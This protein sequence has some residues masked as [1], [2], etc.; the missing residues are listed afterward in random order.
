MLTFIQR[1]APSLTV[2]LLIFST[3]TFAQNN[4]FKV[5]IIGPFTGPSADF[6][7]PMLNGI[8]LAVEE[9]NA[10]GGYL[11]RPLQLVIKDDKANPD[12]GLKQSQA[13]I[14]EKVNVVVGFC[15]TGVAAK[16]LD[17]F[18]T[19]KIPLIIP[20]STGSPLTA[21]FPAPESYI[22]RTSAKDAIQ[23]PFVVEDILKRGW[24]KIAIFA[25]KTG[26]GEAGLQDVLKAL[27]AK[28]IKPVHVARFDVGVK[29]LSEEMKAAKTAGAE[30]IFSYTV[31]P[32]NAVIAKS[33]QA[34]GWKVPQVGAWPLS[35]PF[36]IDG[37]KEAAEGALMAQTFIAEPSNERRAAF[38]TAYARKY[39]TN[40]ISVPMAAA[41]G[42]DAMYILMYS[43]FNLRDGNTAGSAIKAA[44][45]NMPRIYYGVVAT[46][47][48]PFSSNDKDA[49][50]A[51]MLVMGQV[52]NGLV[53]FAYPEDAKRNLIVQRK[54]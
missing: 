15:N 12:E 22:F 38:L 2:G 48:K 13:L 32:E 7:N 17:T 28:K 40:R 52:K 16:S 50:T 24:S 23:A 19:A 33:K 14:A 39:K 9:I 10:V 49:L 25:D 3:P 41:Q 47:D 51:N 1:L 53:T 36:F 46:Y 29:D 54:K 37:A 4:S 42:Y 6:G 11:G 44:L 34:I 18:Q 5:G 30:V 20:C 31:G 21:K 26:Y 8:Q 35:F 27:D 45:E 43:M